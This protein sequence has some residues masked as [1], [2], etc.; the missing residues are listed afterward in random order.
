M[1]RKHFKDYDLL[2]IFA[3]LFVVIGHSAYYSIAGEF[4]ALNYQLPQNL[5]PAYNGWVMNIARYVSGWVYGFHMPLF[6]ILSGAVFAISSN[7]SFDTLCVKKIKRLVIPHFIY[8][9][10]FMIPVKWVANFYDNSTLND[11]YVN[12]L[13]GG[14]QRSSMVPAGLVLGLYS[15]LD[16]QE[17]IFRQ[18]WRHVPA[19]SSRAALSQISAI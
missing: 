15:L 8:C 9:L 6:F 7:Y 5:S 17:N 13:G 3:I 1:D 18:P 16:H 2:R 4:G 14:G 11:A 10:G 12:S 19:Q